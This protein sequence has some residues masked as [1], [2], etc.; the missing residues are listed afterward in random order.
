MPQKKSSVE[1]PTSAGS[2]PSKLLPD[3]LKWTSKAHEPRPAQNQ[4]A[5]PL[6]PMSSSRS[7][8]IETSAAGSP[9]A[10]LP[11]GR[12]TEVN[13]LRPRKSSGAAQVHTGE[14]ET[15]ERTPRVAAHA[16]TPFRPQHKPR[17]SPRGRRA[18]P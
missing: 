1:L 2:G 7:V 13:A 10:N 12:T 14:V 17:S 3:A 18:R 11:F 9:P 15:G 8:G 4:P 5:K 16:T 6:S